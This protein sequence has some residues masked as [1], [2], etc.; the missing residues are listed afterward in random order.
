MS[1]RKIKYWFILILFFSL[2]SIE[3]NGIS[4]ETIKLYDDTV[5]L[6]QV[7]PWREHIIGVFLNK[8][9]KIVFNFTVEQ[10]GPWIRTINM[11]ITDK[12]NFNRRKEFLSWSYLMYKKETTEGNG[13]FK[14]PKTEKYYFI[15]HNSSVF[16][17]KKVRIKMSLEKDEK[18]PTFSVQTSDTRREHIPL[19]ENRQRIVTIEKKGYYYIPYTLDDEFKVEIYFKTNRPIDFLIMTKYDFDRI[20]EKGFVAYKKYQNV[21]DFYDLFTAPIRDVYYFVFINKSSE[22]INLDYRFSFRK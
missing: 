8:G 4:S 13:V 17:N 7:P 15:F 1:I 14:A 5:I 16:L 22:K 6:T 18:N 10:T 2:L 9:D 11:Y 19:P 12:D 21:S 20:K 3:I